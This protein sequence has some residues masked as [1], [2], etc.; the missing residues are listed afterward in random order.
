MK[1]IHTVTFQ[2][3]DDGNMINKTS[4]EE[5]VPVEGVDYVKGDDNTEADA[6]TVCEIEHEVDLL[7]AASKL[8]GIACLIITTISG[9]RALR[10]LN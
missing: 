1:R 10:R 6:T 2:Y 4:V 3:D 9:V 5:L 7:D 8:I